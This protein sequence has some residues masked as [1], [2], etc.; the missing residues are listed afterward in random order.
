MGGVV[1]LSV[2]DMKHERYITYAVDEDSFGMSRMFADYG[3]RLSLAPNG[4]GTQLTI[5]SFYTPRNYFYSLVNTLV[6]KRQF[7][8]V[9]D[10]LLAGLSRYAATKGTSAALTGA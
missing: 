5:E 4:S 9:L 6:M 2:T 1:G 10:G 3:F 8:D 7:S